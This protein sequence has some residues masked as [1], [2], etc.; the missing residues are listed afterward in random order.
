MGH[1]IRK[2]HIDRARIL[3]NLL[4]LTTVRINNTELVVQRFQLL[5]QTSIFRDNLLLILRS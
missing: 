5:P 4:V 2:N 3:S 1:S